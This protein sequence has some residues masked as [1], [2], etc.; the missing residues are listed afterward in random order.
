[1][2]DA[3]PRLALLLAILVFFLGGYFETA[4]LIIGGIAFRACGSFANSP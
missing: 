2:G 1:M 4:L 3:F